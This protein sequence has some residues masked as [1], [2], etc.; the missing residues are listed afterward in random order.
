MGSIGTMAGHHGGRRSVDQEINMVP[1]IDLLMVTISFLLITAVWTSLARIPATS[2][3]PGHHDHSPVRDE[4][5][6]I[7]HVHVNHG[8]AK[9]SFQRGNHVDDVVEHIALSSDSTGR[10]AA[11][12]DAV[13]QAYVGGLSTRGLRGDET[14]EGKVS[15]PNVALVHIENGAPVSALIRVMDAISSPKRRLCTPSCSHSTEVAAFSVTLAD[16]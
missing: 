3:A 4:Q 12:E 6:S 15:E 11:L 13:R 2:Q 14:T 7:L 1:F 9:L 10:L 8:E 5:P 16:R